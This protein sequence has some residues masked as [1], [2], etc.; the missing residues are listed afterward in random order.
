MQNLDK[1][2][3]KIKKEKMEKDA[4]LEKFKDVNYFLEKNQEFRNDW[5]LYLKEE[6]NKDTENE[7]KK[8]RSLYREWKKWDK[9]DLKNMY[10]E[11]L[12]LA[13]IFNSRPI[14]KRKF[15][16]GNL[17]DSDITTKILRLQSLSRELQYFIYPELEASLNFEGTTKRIQGQEIRGTIDWNKT[18]INS[19][20]TG[21]VPLTFVCNIRENDFDLPENRLL[22]LSVMWI[23]NDCEEI[24]RWTGFPKLTDKER[25]DI[26]KTFKTSQIILERTS[27]QKLL[28]KGEMLSHK[29][30]DNPVIRQLI[31]K[32]KTRLERGE[33]LQH[34]YEVLIK[35][36]QN[37]RYFSN[38]KFG[39]IPNRTRIDVRSNIDEMFEYWILYELL[40][41]LK[42]KKDLTCTVVERTEN[43]GMIFLI[44]SQKKE[45]K[46]F[47]DK[48]LYKKDGYQLQVRTSNLIQPDYL[49]ETDRKN[50]PIVMDAKNYDE[51]TNPT[52]AI[53]RILSYVIDLNLHNTKIGIL[54]FP[55]LFPNGENRREQKIKIKG[56]EYYCK[57]CNLKLET[58][59]CNRCH[60]HPTE[61]R[62]VYHLHLISC[63]SGKKEE[64]YE[65]FEFI[66]N[67][68]FKSILE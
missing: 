48:K 13:K 58:E 46:L 36:T 40:F 16:F 6:G 1:E 43:K 30:L 20:Q 14:A 51:K 68:Y 45:I 24:L 7:E 32:V 63:I 2:N 9:T 61:H 23:R 4:E 5:K 11:T 49:I 67:E 29:K 53:D 8:W 59:Q 18:I 65:N 54:F 57:I 41:F 60:F 22:I 15:D 31:G 39:G 47:F 52:G 37:Y 66:Y 17:A 10:N 26:Q 28:V 44:K 35:W 33:I 55:Y 56:L 34:Q 19:A 3:E 50:F 38:K 27:L 62:P 21:G 64:M 42:D 25:K 12:R